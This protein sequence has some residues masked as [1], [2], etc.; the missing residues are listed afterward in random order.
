MTNSLTQS[1]TLQRFESIRIN[2][3]VLQLTQI[4]DKNLVRRR[5]H[6]RSWLSEL[7]IRAVRMT[8]EVAWRQD[9]TPLGFG[10]PMG[11]VPRKRIKK[12][13]GL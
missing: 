6:V 7:W 8:R 13:D 12:G 1:D 10:S 4:A 9:S 3:T 5:L 2:L 11:L